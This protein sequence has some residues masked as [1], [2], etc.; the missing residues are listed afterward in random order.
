MTHQDAIERIRDHMLIHH[1]YQSSE[2]YNVA[3]AL[4]IASE[5]LKAQEPMKPQ[6][7]HFEFHYASYDEYEDR[8]YCP[9]CGIRLIQQ[10][11]YCPN[12]GRAVKWND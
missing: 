8:A 7:K 3:E 11:N 6:V 1:M 10:V 2:I 4:N 9:K 5:A 12:C